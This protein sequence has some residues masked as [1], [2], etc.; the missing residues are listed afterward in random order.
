MSLQELILELAYAALFVIGYW[1]LILIFNK[2]SNKFFKAI[3]VG[4]I[5]PFFS[6][7]FMINFIIPVNYILH[8]T[9]IFK[10]DYG[11][12]TLLF[13]VYAKPISIFLGLGLMVYL[14]K[15]TNN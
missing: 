14:L 8:I 12:L 2:I 4:L 10:D 5:T 9:G 6:Y 15:K 7:Q 3:L 1:I 11:I 13:V